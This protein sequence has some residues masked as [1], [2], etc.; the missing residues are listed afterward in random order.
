MS[1]ISVDLSD[2]CGLDYGAREE[3]VRA[4]GDHNG[5][6]LLFVEGETGETGRI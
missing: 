4:K 5:A 2:N 1:R 6:R 3:D